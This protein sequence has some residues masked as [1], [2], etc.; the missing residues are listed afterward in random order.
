[1]QF[2]LG[3]I[4]E[5][6]RN[7]G[8]IESEAASFDA[9]INDATSMLMKVGLPDPRENH[10]KSFL[11][12]FEVFPF[13]RNHTGAYCCVVR[14]GDSDCDLIIPSVELFRTYFGSSSTLLSRLASGSDERLWEKAYPGGAEGDAYIKLSPGIDKA[15]GLDVAR[16]AFCD[17]ARRAALG[18]WPALSKQSAANMKPYLMM[19]FPFEG[20][21]RL[22]VSGQWL[23]AEGSRP[24][25]LVRRIE[26]C[27]HPFPFN[28]LR[29]QPCRVEK[30]K[31]VEKSQQDGEEQQKRYMRRAE[32]Q[33]IDFSVDQPKQ[34]L[35]APTFNVE[36][37]QVFPDLLAKPTVT[38][39]ETTIVS[40]E[41]VN[42]KAQPTTRA[43]GDD[44]SGVSGGPNRGE[45]TTSDQSEPQNFKPRK[46]TELERLIRQVE[47]IIMRE[48]QLPERPRKIDVRL[49]EM[50]P[51]IGAC[52]L[53]KEGYLA[54]L[55]SSSWLASILEGP[56]IGDLA[57]AQE[58]L[59]KDIVELTQTARSNRSAFL[60]GDSVP[61][62]N[63]AVSAVIRQANA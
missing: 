18:I 41:L 24:R 32:T 8:A 47:D 49:N 12:P 60:F 3:S 23:R 51:K 55:K 35:K 62:V 7:T 15:S 25:F 4:W 16:I 19:G 45:L 50:G 53:I 21:S 1:M 61:D 13:H 39:R 46:A 38:M 17:R 33:E 9:D 57:S 11:L 63:A 26:Q 54:V 14:I 20:R 48:L 5:D 52:F 6:G 2:P 28:T 36:R 58:L 27:T 43:V 34:K 44:A 31:T 56:D 22:S 59:L 40:E 10:S 30:V 42:T 29:I 37:G